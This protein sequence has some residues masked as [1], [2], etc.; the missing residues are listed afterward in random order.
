MKNK[1]TIQLYANKYGENNLIQAVLNKQFG[2]ELN[3]ENET[4][5]SRKILTLDELKTLKNSIDIALT[6]YKDALNYKIN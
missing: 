1:V 2:F 3:F 6:S 5:R 4:E